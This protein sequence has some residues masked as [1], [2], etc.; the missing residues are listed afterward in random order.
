[1]LDYASLQLKHSVF[2]ASHTLYLL[3]CTNPG[4]STHSAAYLLTGTDSSDDGLP[5]RL[6]EEDMI[7]KRYR[8]GNVPSKSFKT[9]KLSRDDDNSM[10]D[11]DCSFL[12]QTT[13]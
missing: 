1:M 4:Y 11:E 10:Y 8:G 5:D 13:I 7:D 12:S 9:L 2:F 3:P 6:N